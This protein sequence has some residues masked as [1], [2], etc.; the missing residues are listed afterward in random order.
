MGWVSI[1]YSVARFYRLCGAEAHAGFG[2]SIVKPSCIREGNSE[3]KAVLKNSDP[4]EHYQLKILCLIARFR[5]HQFRRELTSTRY[6]KK[7]HR[8]NPITEL[9]EIE[10]HASGKACAGLLALSGIV[11]AS[12]VARLWRKLRFR[13]YL[14]LTATPQPEEGL[15]NLH[16]SR[17]WNY[18]ACYAY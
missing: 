9:S 8:A 5:M 1:L 11:F 2:Q 3:T 18:P 4:E 15:E 12:D 14:F 10:V 6:I 13:Q 17:T 7:V 16:L